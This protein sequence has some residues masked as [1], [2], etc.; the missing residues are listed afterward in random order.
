MTTSATD[1]LDSDDGGR[2]ST[3]ADPSAWRGDTLAAVPLHAYLVAG[4]VAALPV[5][6]LLALLARWVFADSS[7]RQ[8]A[9]PQPP[10]FGLLVPIAIRA[11]DDELDDVRRTLD[12]HGI[13][14]TT[15]DTADGLVVLVFADDATSASGLVAAT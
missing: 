2:R 3:R 9:A 8:G 6:A 5:I 10:D 12:A 4:P 14:S 15:A 1:H 7:R 13:R 11:T